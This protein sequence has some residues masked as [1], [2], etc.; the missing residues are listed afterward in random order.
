MAWVYRERRW[1]VKS[2]VKVSGST[3]TLQLILAVSG[4][5]EV[6]GLRGV[7]VKYLYITKNTDCE[8]SSLD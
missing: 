5:V 2:V 7:A 8:A 3:V 6:G 1:T 4:T